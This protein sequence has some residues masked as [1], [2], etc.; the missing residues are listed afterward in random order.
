MTG[1]P[2]PHLKVEGATH[3]PSCGT[4]VAGFDLNPCLPWGSLPKLY[5]Q[6]MSPDRYRDLYEQ[7]WSED[8]K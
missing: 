3:C 1:L 2:L 6:Y 7:K 8:E 5:V 4:P